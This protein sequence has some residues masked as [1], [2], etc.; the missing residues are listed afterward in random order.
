L[1]HTQFYYRPSGW[2]HGARAA[3]WFG[4]PWGW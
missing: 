1:V 3:A 4:H 2:F